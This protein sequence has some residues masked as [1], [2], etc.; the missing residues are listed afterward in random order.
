M[1][2]YIGDYVLANYGT[3]VVMAVPAH[4]ERDFDFAK[5]H[6]IIVIQS[7]LPK[8][9]ENYNFEAFTTLPE[10]A[11]EKGILVN[12]DQFS[13]LTSDEA[14]TKIQD[15]LLEQ[16]IGGKKI[17]YKIQDWVFSRQRYWG[18]PFPIVFCDNC[19]TVPMKES[20]LPLLLPDVEHYE[21]TGT[22]E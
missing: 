20:D 1:P 16:G 11:T 6:G 10:K 14:I 12:S 8:D 5:K 13:G 2:I 3:G 18:E 19:G 15:W 9:K 22:E 21:P 17:N 7:I 4:D